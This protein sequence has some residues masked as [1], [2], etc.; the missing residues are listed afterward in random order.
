MKKLLITTALSAGFAV[1]AA[2]AAIF[3]FNQQ[4]YEGG[5]SFYGFFEAEDLNGDGQIV[6]F[7]GEVT[8][9]QATF[10]GFA[11]GEQPISTNFDF[12]S[13][14]GTE[15]TATGLVYSL[16]G[17]GTIGDDRTRAIEGLGLDNGN[18]AIQVGPGPTSVACDGE[19]SCG[20]LSEAGFF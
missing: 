18:F 12:D 11:F 2:Q 16:D 1:S 19:T 9:I 6:S 5:G 14:I 15:S 10:D 7:D 17:G 13:L 3:E 20:F 4:G 8:D